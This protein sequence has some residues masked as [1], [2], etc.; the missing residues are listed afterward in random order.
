MLRVSNIRISINDNEDKLEDEI[1]KTLKINKD[2]LISYKIFRESIDARSRHNIYFIYTID[3]KVKDEEDVLKESK[4]NVSKSSNLSYHPVQKGEEF[5]DNPP[6][7]VGAGPAGLYAALILAQRGYNPI[8]LERG[9]KVVERDE[10]V[11]KF[12]EE[13]E[14]N[15]ESNVQF[16]EGGAGTFSDGKLT[17]RI[18]D[19]RSRKVIDELIEGGAPEEIYY[20][21]KAHVG[22]DILREVV[23]NIRKKIISLGGKVRFEAKVTDLIVDEGK[24]KGV[25]VNSNEMIES[26]VVL[27]AIGHSAR[28]T[29]EK[30]YNRGIKIKQKS[31][32]MGVR[33]EHPQSMIDKVQYGKFA[34]HPKLGVADYQIAYQASNGR[35]V[36]TFCM[37]PGGVVVGAASE[38]GRLVTNGMS[39][40]SRNEE[41]ANSALLVSVGPDDFGSDHPLAG[42]EFQRKWET[43]AFEV[44][45]GGYSA[46]VQLVKDFLED[47][48]SKSLGEV[49]PS[50]KP[51]VTLTNLKDC[52]P[53]YVVEAMK[54]GI[55][56]LD[57]KLKGFALEDGVMTGVETR[58]SSPIRIER[59]SNLESNIKGI[60]PLGEGAGY[61]GGI[62]SA[63]VDGIKGA[64]RVIEKFS[65]P[66]DE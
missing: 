27:L 50:Y 18:K 2:D 28:D 15:P 29:F 61:A 17:T 10:D 59:G 6:I 21:K 66:L 8:L 9:K 55:V 37:C 44:G 25:E 42:V 63:A 31:F 60:Y 58:S 41:N 26:K 53:T 64:E 36:Y 3:V 5:L 1:V 11:K 13:G 56:E 65:I 62:I 57:K 40:Y 54:E 32:A 34:N 7:V 22:T 48:A 14:L 39:Y 4:G 30:L 24:V 43:K 46:P 47:R 19:L 20:K 45:G 38:E 12:W 16:G 35:G 33:V 51:A 23:Q 52:L 49:N